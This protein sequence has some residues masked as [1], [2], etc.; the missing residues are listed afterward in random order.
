MKAA[1]E[2]RYF[3]CPVLTATLIMTETT[4]VS[5]HQQF[6]FTDDGDLEPTSESVETSLASFGAKVDTRD[7]ESRPDQPTA[8]SLLCD[9]RPLDDGSK[10]GEQ[11]T[12]YPDVD[13]DQRALDGSQAST[14]STFTT[15]ESPADPRFE[16]ALAHT[17]DGRDVDKALRA[18]DGIGEQT[19]GVL[20][21]AGITDQL[22]LALAWTK[23]DERE[24]LERA[25]DA[26][27]E[28]CQHTVRETAAGL[29]RHLHR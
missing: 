7:R 25:L 23:P 12:L 10:G 5:T 14:I 3:S 28:N 29:W 19:T 17:L 24:D 4:D 27:P 18:V 26:L 13:D 6:A 8:S 2:T 1:L 22:D 16:R 20:M 9:D 21:A 11:A 15:P